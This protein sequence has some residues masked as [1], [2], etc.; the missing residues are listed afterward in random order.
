MHIT[1][2]KGEMFQLFCV[3][4]GYNR[5]ELVDNPMCDWSCPECGNRDISYRSI[6]NENI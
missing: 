3:K 4:C 2:K 6:N 1:I 5:H